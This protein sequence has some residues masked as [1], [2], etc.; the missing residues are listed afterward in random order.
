MEEIYRVIDENWP[1]VLLTWYMFNL[2][3]QK[4]PEP[5]DSDG[6]FY[7]WSF[8]MLHGIAGNAG[9]IKKVVLR[10]RSLGK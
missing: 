4:M 7:T 1:L 10:R 9:L 2:A 3:V 6:K 5:E 8:G